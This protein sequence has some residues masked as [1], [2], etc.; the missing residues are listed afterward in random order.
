[1]TLGKTG[2]PYADRIWNI[3]VGCTR[4]CT[5]CWARPL[6]RR[7]GRNIGC[8][9]CATFTPHVH[10]D[11]LRD[12]TTGQ[13]PARIGVGF[14][15]DLLAV[16]RW[17]LVWGE[18]H[19]H[20]GDRTPRELLELEL[21]YVFHKCAQHRFLIPTRCPRMIQPDSAWPGNVAF[22]VTCTDQD[23]ANARLPA[24]LE[25]VNGQ[26][27]VIANLEPLRGPVVLDPAWLHPQLIDADGVRWE[28]G[29]P[30]RAGCWTNHKALAA[31][32]VGG[33]SG[34]KADPMP[35]AWPRMLRDQCLE[36]EIPYYFKQWGEWHH[37]S[38][39]TNERYEHARGRFR[40]LRGPGVRPLDGEVGFAFRVGTKAA[41]HILDG[42]QWRE[43][44]MGLLV[45]GEQNGA[46]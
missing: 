46:T 32:I 14:M 26:A 40:N 24:A 35:P 28:D 4:G 16:G 44:P 34:P 19:R 20:V 31:V 43:L 36:A 41:G 22:L 10:A 7:V 25:R 13:R 8:R 1:M 15:T 37:E 27:L 39:M 12:P 29:D 45:R 42:R 38:Q 6:A 33:M 2:I 18:K 17:P 3:A 11:R 5:Y 21:G 30:G 23:E 9:L